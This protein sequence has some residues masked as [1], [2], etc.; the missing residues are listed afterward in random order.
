MKVL[1]EFVSNNN[2]TS[3]FRLVIFLL[4]KDYLFSPS[5]P[6]THSPP[7]THR[8]AHTCT[9]SLSHTHTLTLTFTHTLSRS[10][11]HPLSRAHSHT[12]SLSHALTHSLSLSLTPTD[13]IPFLAFNIGSDPSVSDFQ[14]VANYAGVHILSNSNQ[15]SKYDLALKPSNKGKNRPNLLCYIGNYS[16]LYCCSQSY[17]YS[18]FCF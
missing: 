3:F 17:S 12:P 5:L 10:H 18:N 13:R 11:T 2:F 15:I 6:H 4:I 9:H 14:T 8:R 7:F 1:Y 16:C